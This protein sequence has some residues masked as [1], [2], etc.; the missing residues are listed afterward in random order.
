MG[1][2]YRAKY[3]KLA[4]EVAIK[5]L[6]AALAR[7]PDRFARGAK[8]LASLN[9][10]NVAQIYEIEDRALIMQL[11]DGATVTEPAPLTKAF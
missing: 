9:H 3:P 8:L 6:P 1:E 2:V 11:A 7:D 4:R 10:L 5:I